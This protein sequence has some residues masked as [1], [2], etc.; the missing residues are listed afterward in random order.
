MSYVN[1]YKTRFE[2]QSLVAESATKVVMG[3]T[4]TSLSTTDVTQGETLDGFTFI[5][6]A[7]GPDV[8]NTV[9]QSPGYNGLI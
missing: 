3:P 6:L 7:K 9:L 5:S 4:G 1:L 8:G 2:L